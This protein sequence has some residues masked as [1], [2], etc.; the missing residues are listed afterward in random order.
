MWDVHFSVGCSLQGKEIVLL[1][2]FFSL[3]SPLHMEALVVFRGHNTKC[4]NLFND[5]SQLKCPSCKSEACC[6]T[7][8]PN[9]IQFAF[10]EVLENERALWMSTKTFSAWGQEGKR[11][12]KGFCSQQ[13]DGREVEAN[14]DHKKAYKNTYDCWWR[15]AHKEWSVWFEMFS[16]AVCFPW[17]RLPL[18]SF[19]GFCQRCPCMSCVFFSFLSS[20]SSYLFDSALKNILIKVFL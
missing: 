18:P 16:L 14:S 7:C 15:E 11:K 3:F 1:L 12:H 9:N 19:C 17:S 2:V 13:L 6:F 8:F 10:E 20:P 5:I 4:D